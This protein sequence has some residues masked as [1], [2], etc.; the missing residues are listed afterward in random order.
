MYSGLRDAWL[1]TGNEQAKVIF[2]KFCDWAISVTASLSEAQMQS[3]LDTEHGGMNEVLADAYQMTHDKK[4]LNA[5]ER[6]SHKMLLDPM[7]QGK[8]NL[9]NKHVVDRD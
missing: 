2:L 3:M 8:D 6:F 1:Y 9:D 7:S 4:Y 5:A